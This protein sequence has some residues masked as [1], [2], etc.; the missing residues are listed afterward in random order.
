[1]QVNSYERDKDARKRC[2]DHFGAK[3]NVC[4]LDFQEKYG[5]I[6]A[7]FIH[8]HHKVEISTIGKEYSVNPKTDLIPVC[9]NCH[10]IL[11]KESQHIQ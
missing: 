7:G 9:P 6:G 2:I 10:S 8:V 11:R 1:M 3:C 4:G 5:E